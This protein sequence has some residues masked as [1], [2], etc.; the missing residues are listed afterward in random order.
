MKAPNT[1]WKT[2]N[3]NETIWNIWKDCCFLF[4]RFVAKRVNG[5]FGMSCCHH[6]PAEL[7]DLNMLQSSS[8]RWKANAFLA[9]LQRFSLLGTC[10]P[11]WFWFGFAVCHAWFGPGSV[12]TR[13]QK[14]WKN[15]TRPGKAFS[16]ALGL[17][18]GQWP[19][20]AWPIVHVRLLIQHV[21]ILCP[22]YFY[23]LC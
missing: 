16:G 1:N 4:S 22:M 21:L 3:T 18:S 6:F 14:I 5:S 10:V 2:M 17:G 23:A 20:M 8:D 7:V 9:F 11:R 13:K 12:K 15:S 19:R